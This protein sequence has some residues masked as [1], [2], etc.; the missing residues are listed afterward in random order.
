[1]RKHL[2]YALTVMLL[3]GAL[4][5][6]QAKAFLFLPPGPV[7]PT[8]D[9]STDS[10][11]ALDGATKKVAAGLEKIEGKANELS[12]KIKSLKDENVV[13]RW[14]AK[15]KEKTK[16]VLSMKKE[17]GEPV[18]EDVKTIEECTIADI[19]DEASVSDAFKVLFA[20]YPVDILEKHPLDSEMVKK[21]YRQKSVEFSNDVM[22]EAYLVSRKLEERMLALKEDYETLSKCYVDGESGNGDSCQA[23]SD[24]DD[25]IGIWTNY[26]R[27]NLIYDSLLRIAEELTALEA[28][29]QA[30]QTMRVGIDPVMPEIEKDTNEQQSFNLTIREEMAFA[31]V[32]TSPEKS[33]ETQAT[34]STAQNEP[35]TQNETLSKLK[36]ALSLVPMPKKEVS[37]FLTGTE[38]QFEGM[39]SFKKVYNKLKEAQNLHN[40]KAQV[41]S[42]RTI[43]KNYHQVEI[44]HNETVKRLAMAEDCAVNYLSNFYENPSQVWYG[45]GCQNLGGVVTCDGGRKASA[46]ALKS[47]T[48]DDYLCGENNT[49][50]CSNFGINK[51]ASRGGFSGWL[52]SSYQTVKAQTALEL[53]S[54]DF[55]SPLVDASSTNDINELDEQ[56]SRLKAEQESGVADS[57]LLRPS[58]EEPNEQDL[59]EENLLT[60]HIGA[61][62]AKSIGID[63]SSNSPKWGEVKNPFPVWED[64][65][66]FYKEYLN[67][68]YQ[69]IKIFINNLDMSASAVE[70]VDTML[71][72]LSEGLINDVP[73]VEVKTYGKSV[74]SSLSD[75]AENVDN[76]EEIN[77]LKEQIEKNN[78]EKEILKE[79]FENKLK[80]LESS[81]KAVYS[82]L[83]D[84]NIALN[85]Q[86]QTYNT[87]LSDKRTA[88][89][90]ISGQ[91]TFTA[92]SQERNESKKYATDDYLNISSARKAEAEETKEQKQVEMDTTFNS[93]EVKRENIDS[94]KLRIEDVND[95]IERTKSEYA[96]ELSA[97]EIKNEALLEK[98]LAIMKKPAPTLKG[99]GA[100]NK[101]LASGSD[102]SEVK[103]VIFSGLVESADNLIANAK[104][105]AIARVDEALEQLKNLGNDLY[106]AES[107][108]KVLQIHTDMIEDIT[109]PDLTADLGALETLIN[110]DLIQDAASAAFREALKAATCDKVACDTPDTQYFV[111]LPAKAQ[112]FT[113]PKELISGY[114]PPLRE[115]VHFDTVD[116]DNVIKSD[117]DKIGHDA[118]LT[119]GEE[120][121]E[122]WH[123]ILEPKA[124]ID[125]D[126]SVKKML[127]SY[128]KNSNILLSEDG[129]KSVCGYSELGTLLSYD[130]GITFNPKMKEIHQYFED[131]AQSDSQDDSD[132]KIKIYKNALLTRN[133]FGDYL[134]FVELE[135]SY[136]ETLSKLE[137]KLDEARQ[138][139]REALEKF[140]FEL[141][142]NFDLADETTY[143]EIMNK[144][145]SAKNSIVS[146]AIPE[147]GRIEPANEALEEN[148]QKLNDMVGALQLD[149]DEVVALSDTMK[150]DAELSEKIKAKTVD[151][152]ALARYDNEAKEAMKKE[153]DNFGTPYCATFCSLSF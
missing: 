131:V 115:I 63:M 147:I 32:L 85:G 78:Q 88:E 79:N 49:E 109:N 28:E 81:K 110:P 140:G 74:T 126:F 92:R 6:S 138:T 80:A 4:L 137:V 146:E 10:A 143:N 30:A 103:K 47:M 89:A 2:L 77:S 13:S 135:T 116:Y 152:E 54:D 7:T 8:I 22:L 18:V 40:L 26:Y 124:F 12:T 95:Q 31:Q 98:A 117:E 75:L 83:D 21:A 15:L 134:N 149:K 102:Q 11:T 69:N 73:A 87:A 132:D 41:P 51:Y 43:F 59:R 65:K 56:A 29:Y 139:L 120:V 42:F 100:L 129:Q 119:Y 97:I 71:D 91:D 68:K 33:L 53:T 101:A 107:A 62:A 136:Q 14:L 122:I 17:K 144:L 111:G 118:L 55:A 106:K 66:Y 96:A 34:G 148:I 121:P 27:V 90:N 38:K 24:T 133:Q 112:D 25:E 36:A 67:E 19:K 61:E 16:K 82:R 142:E 3:L 20:V 153:I 93:V 39:T 46:E 48:K 105:Q 35:T 50:I 108:P 99:N 70:I 145:D 60:F 128:G 94:L 123:R 5:N 150:A 72:S 44:L 9:A 23:A 141:E 84:E 58:E 114:T 130:N 1:M 57:G 45:N 127:E 113:A 52:L 64:E 76:D 86:K 125:R 37:T 104:K 151:S